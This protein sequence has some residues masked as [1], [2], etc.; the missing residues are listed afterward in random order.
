M[1]SISVLDWLVDNYFS[2][3]VLCCNFKIITTTVNLLVVKGSQLITEEEVYRDNSLSTLK[4]GKIK[5]KK[6]LQ[7]IIHLYSFVDDLS[8]EMN[9]NTTDYTA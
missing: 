4:E 1:I 2:T 6:D 9:E 3:S 5:K 7:P 8:R